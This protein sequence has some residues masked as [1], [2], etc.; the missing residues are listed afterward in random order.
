MHQADRE[1]LELHTAEN[2]L[3]EFVVAE[4]T[5]AERRTLRYLTVCN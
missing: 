1:G 2:G 5:K 3:Q 4:Q